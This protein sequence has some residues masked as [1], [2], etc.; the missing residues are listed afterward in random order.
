MI[1]V[2]VI[3]AS[4]NFFRVNTAFLLFLDFHV[5]TYVLTIIGLVA[6]KFPMT[7]LISCYF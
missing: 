3:N 5:L 1:I 7:V 6:I 4:V 2:G